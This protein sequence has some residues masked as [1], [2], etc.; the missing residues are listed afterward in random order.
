MLKI[1]TNKSDYQFSPEL[2]TDTVSYDLPLTLFGK[3]WY[4]MDDYWMKHIHL[5]ITDRCNAACPF[6]IE[7]NSHIRENKEQLLANVSRLLDEMDAQGHLAT[8]SITGGE[9]ALCDYVGE[10]VDMVKRHNCFL[11]I[12]SNFSRFIASNLQPSWLNISCHTLGTD[13]YCH[14]AEL[15]EQVLKDYY[16]YETWRLNG[17]LITLSHSN[18]GLLRRMEENEP[19]NL[20]REI[21]VHPDGHISGSWYRNRKVICSA[22]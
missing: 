6:C 7:Q 19:D 21:V 22:K 14:L 11:N 4:I 2:A 17:T 5:K 9:P 10:V 13:D 1:I 8:V 16:V 3:Q 15:I 18:M 12:N 20:L